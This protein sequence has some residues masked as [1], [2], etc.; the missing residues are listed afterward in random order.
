MVI[1]RVAITITFFSTHSA[2]CLVLVGS[3]SIYATEEL[4]FYERFQRINNFLWFQCNSI[5]WRFIDVMCLISQAFEGRNESKSCWIMRLHSGIE[6]AIWNIMKYLV[7]VRNKCFYD[8][9]N[10]FN[11][12][13]FNWLIHKL[14]FMFPFR[15]IR[16]L[17]YERKEQ[18]CGSIASG[19]GECGIPRAGKVASSSECN[20]FATRQGFNHSTHDIVP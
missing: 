5:S 6:V 7:L 2:W 11:D 14:S 12:C 16:A 20:Y 8:W 1:A 9:L 4:S 15:L 18:E 10:Q 17:C 3:I 19:E 13:T